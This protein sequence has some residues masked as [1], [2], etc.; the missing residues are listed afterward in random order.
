MGL[1]GRLLSGEYGRPVTQGSALRPDPELE[2]S[3]LLVAQSRFPIQ[4]YMLD[5][6]LDGQT[7]GQMHGGPTGWS[8]SF[9][10]LPTAPASWTEHSLVQP[11]DGFYRGWPEGGA[12]QFHS[13]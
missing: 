13:F 3:L 2:G 11:R 9:F 1:P 8:L 6:R 10:L 7:E 12:S 4:G 5:R